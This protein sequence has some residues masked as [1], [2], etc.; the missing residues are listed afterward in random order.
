MISDWLVKNIG[1]FG[2]A[3][4]L[5]VA[6]LAFVIWRFNPVFKVPDIKRKEKQIPDIEPLENEEEDGPKLFVDESF[7]TNGKGNSLKN[8]NGVVIPPKENFSQNEIGDLKVI[9]K[10]DKELDDEMEDAD[11]FPSYEELLPKDAEVINPIEKAPKPKKEI[12][13]PEL[14]IKDLSE[15]KVDVE[16]HEAFCAKTTGAF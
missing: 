16:E 12:Q 4:V 15:K 3:A 13:I 11:T 9:E 1:W 8:G 5:L 10:D 6:G 14:E 7:N 2:T